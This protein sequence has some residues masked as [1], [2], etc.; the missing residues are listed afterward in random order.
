[1]RSANNAYPCADADLLSDCLLC[2]IQKLDDEEKLEQERLDAKLATEIAFSEENRHSSRRRG[3]QP[4][5][6]RAITPEA[7]EAEEE[8]LLEKFASNKQPHC[9]HG[10]QCTRSGKQRSVRRSES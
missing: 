8:L 10:A 1:M 3:L 4:Y 7:V 9:P 2:T 6:Q 5:G